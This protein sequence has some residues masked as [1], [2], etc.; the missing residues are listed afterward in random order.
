MR[1]RAPRWI[2]AGNGVAIRW[3]R[4]LGFTLMPESSILG[5][6]FVPFYME[7]EGHAG[8]ADAYFRSCGLVV[9]AEEIG[10]GEKPCV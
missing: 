4:W 9:N 2:G 3:L 7:R 5:G 8:I 1:W 6:A 10:E